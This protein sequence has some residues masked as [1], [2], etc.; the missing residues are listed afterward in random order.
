MMS[1]CV[2][3]SSSRRARTNA[4]TRIK[5]SESLR[6]VGVWGPATRPYIVLAPHECKP[7]RRR[8]RDTIS[9]Y[10]KSHQFGLLT[11]PR[12]RN[13]CARSASGARRR[14][15]M[16]NLKAGYLTELRA[17]AEAWQGGE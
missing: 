10:M 12:E 16:T 9:K 7:P 8:M 5:C 2:R 6:D 1:P 14:R 11:T 13:G 3:P 15:G 17:H 4:P